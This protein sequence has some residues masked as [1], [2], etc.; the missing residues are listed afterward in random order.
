MKKLFLT[1]L[2]L[3]I[4]F[5]VFAQSAYEKVMAD[6]IAKIDHCKTYDEFTALSND[7]S[8]IGDKEKT[9]WLPYYYAALSTIQGGRTLMRDNKTDGLDT[10]GDAA[11]NYITK[12]EALSPDTAELSI[13]SKMAHG[14]KM[15]VDPMSRY[16]T[17]GQAA[18]K[19]LEA[20][21]KKDPNNPRI[22]ILQAEDL[23]FTPEQFGGDKKK[24][25]ETFQKAK[26]LFKTYKPKTPLD[27]NWGEGEA[28]YFL[29]QIK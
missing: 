5:S 26:E 25:K 9:Q 7:F 20:A 18:Q 8:R 2:L 29:A 22:A 1:T 14:L 21:I 13:L 28:D 15:M 12:A 6:K 3:F 16:M 10:A 19:A 23:Y 27:P 24:A 17:E 11:I 4:G